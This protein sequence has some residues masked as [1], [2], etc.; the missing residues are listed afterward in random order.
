MLCSIEKR[1]DL[2]NRNVSVSL[3]NQIK[4]LRLQDELGKQTSYENMKKVL[5]IRT[6]T[7]RDASENITKTISE[8][9]K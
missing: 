8:T 1:E 5:E 4:P 9:Y 2:E 3:Q 6:R 7:C